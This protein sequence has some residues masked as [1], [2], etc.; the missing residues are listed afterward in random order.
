MGLSGLSEL[1]NIIILLYSDIVFI[2]RISCIYAE[3]Y[4]IPEVFC[5]VLF[6]WKKKKKDKQIND[7]F[8]KYTPYVTVQ[9]NFAYNKFKF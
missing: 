4:K 2:H 9:A 8:Y 1:F 5:F 3:F 6:L 7:P